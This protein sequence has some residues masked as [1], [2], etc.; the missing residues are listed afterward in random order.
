[1]PLELKKNQILLLWNS[2]LQLFGE[3]EMSTCNN[4]SFLLHIKNSV[5]FENIYINEFDLNLALETNTVKQAKSLGACSKA[6]LVK[7]LV[8]LHVEG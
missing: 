2:Y 1:M 5:K 6:T 3:P 4:Y 8:L 7:K